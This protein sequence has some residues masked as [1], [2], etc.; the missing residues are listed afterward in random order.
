[1][2]VTPNPPPADAPR[3]FN[4]LDQLRD[5]VHIASPNQ[6]PDVLIITGLETLLPDTLAAADG[7][8]TAQLV[9]AIQPLNLGRNIL[10]KM[11]PCPVL[12]CLPPS[13]MAMLLQS[14]PDLGSW[15]SGFFQFRSDVDAVR[16]ELS[17]DA[18]RDTLVDTVATR[19]RPPLTSRLRR[20]ISKLLSPMPKL[21]LSIPRSLHDSMRDSGG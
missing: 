16:A 11:F 19:W 3:T 21:S 8:P 14:A 7:Q 4:V 20:S 2:T 10:A 13:A 12:L 1:M 17:R 6:V 5:L 9:R 15:Q 18:R